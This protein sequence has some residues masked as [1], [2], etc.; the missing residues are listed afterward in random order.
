MSV[1]LD[2]AE[3]TESTATAE[4]RHRRFSLNEY[5]KM[6]E[7]GILTDRDRCELI[8]GEILEKNWGSGSPFPPHHRFSLDSYDQ[9][10]ATG[11]LTEQ[12]RVELIRGEIIEKMT[13]GQPHAAC[14]K[15]LNQLFSSLL[16]N[17]VVVG[18]QDPVAALESRPEP[19]VS[20]LVARDN[21]YTDSVPHPV[22]VLLLIEVADSS[23]G[24]DRTVKLSLYAES[25]VREYWIANLIDDCVEVYRDPQPDGT[26]ADQRIATLGETLTISALPEISVAVD[27]V[28]GLRRDQ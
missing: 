21:F 4:R 28:F 26:F 12:D 20:I 10:I 22:D 1:A 16:G 8:R 18:I 9:M 7:F 3:Q 25:G 13:I 23:L 24:Y 11:I 6:I 27:Q 14:V 15:R 2:F 19:D 5:T 17:R